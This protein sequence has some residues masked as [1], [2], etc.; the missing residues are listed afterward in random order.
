M[1]FAYALLCSIA[2]HV[3]MQ[4][5]YRQSIYRF[6]KKNNDWLPRCFLP[7]E[8]TSNTYKIHFKYIIY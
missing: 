2:W 5:I 3:G 1:A 8:Q 4:S 6:S 7:H